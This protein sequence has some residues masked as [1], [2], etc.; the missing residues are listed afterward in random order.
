MPFIP[1]HVWAGRAP[2]PPV[3][4]RGQF[5]ALGSSSAVSLVEFR[6]KG[7]M[8]A[9]TSCKKAPGPILAT[10]PWERSPGHRGWQQ[11]WGELQSPAHPLAP[12]GWR[13]HMNSLPSSC[14]MCSPALTTPDLLPVG[15]WGPRQQLAQ[16]SV[17]H[18]HLSAPKG[19]QAPEGC[20]AGPAPL[21]PWLAQG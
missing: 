1:H 7:G 16:H 3:T 13:S 21:L 20:E 6:E 5:Q 15:R 18:C 4:P 12:T 11:G 10:D 8:Q 2:C 19:S 17:C 14:W 9:P